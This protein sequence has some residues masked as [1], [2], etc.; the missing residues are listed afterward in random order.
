[1]AANK[2]L[3]R[4]K[5]VLVEKKKSSLWL[6]IGLDLLK[7]LHIPLFTDDRQESLLRQQQI[8]DKINNIYQEADEC[9]LSANRIM[10]E[11]KAKVERMIIGE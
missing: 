6:S 7:S 3:N 2:D 1:M 11:A 5:V 4:L 10:N 8:V 9:V